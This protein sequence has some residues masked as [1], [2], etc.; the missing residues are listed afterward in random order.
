MLDRFDPRLDASFAPV[1]QDKLIR[2][3]RA[4]L[5][6]SGLLTEVEA[7]RPYGCDGLSAYRCLPFAVALPDSTEAYDALK[8]LLATSHNFPVFT[9]T[10]QLVEVLGRELSLAVA[11][12]KTPEEALATVDEEFAE[13]ARKDGKLKE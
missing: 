12:E 5:P 4:I 8:N 2:G 13:L 1:S 7:L 10:P 3:L 6:A 11:G 9:Y